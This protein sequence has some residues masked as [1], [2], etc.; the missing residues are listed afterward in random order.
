MEKGVR[1]SLLK[2]WHWTN[3]GLYSVENEKRPCVVGSSDW[4]MVHI[5]LLVDEKQAEA[6]AYPGIRGRKVRFCALVGNR[7][8][9]KVQ[10]IMI[11]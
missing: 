5:L 7:R 10:K 1:D 2:N 8:S 4:K 6:R 9:I 3:L 11:E